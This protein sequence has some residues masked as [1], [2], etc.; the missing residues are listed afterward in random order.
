MNFLFIPSWFPEPIAKAIGWTLIHSLWQGLLVTFIAGLMILFTKRSAASIRYKLLSFLLFAFVA[1]ALATFVIEYVSASKASEVVTIVNNT[2]VDLTPVVVNEPVATGSEAGQS[3]FSSGYFSAFTN[4]FNTNAPLIVTIWF[5]IF[6][7]KCFRLT[8]NIASAQRIRKH[9][10]S[11]LPVLQRRLEELAILMKIKALV[12]VHESSIV[13]VPSVIGFLKPVILLPVGLLSNLPPDQVEAIL[14]HELAHIRRKDY[15]VNLLQCVVVT[16]FFFNPSILWLSSLIR[17]ERE[18][19][20]D[21]MAI[22]IL[23]TK[24][25]Y[26]N[27]LVAFTEY[28]SHS[29][30]AQ[31]FPGEKYP[32]LQRIKRIVYNHNKNLNNMEKIF[33]SS[34]VVL[35]AALILTFSATSAQEPVKIEQEKTPT[36][37][38]IGEKRVSEHRQVDG[39]VNDKEF[40]GS[41]TTSRDGKSYTIIVKNNV[42]KGLFVDS[43]RIPDEK[44]GDYKSMTDQIIADHINASNER[45]R[46]KE[47]EKESKAKEK[48]KALKDKQ[49]EYENKKKD[50]E[51]KV[52]EEKENKREKQEEAKEEMEEKRR[53]AKED[54]EEKQREEKEEKEEKEFDLKSEKEFNLKND[55]DFKVKS[56]K[57][58]EYKDKDGDKFKKNKL[59]KVKS[60][61]DFEYQKDNKDAQ[62]KKIAQQKEKE[63]EKSQKKEAD[64][65]KEK[66]KAQQKEQ[67]SQQKQIEREKKQ[68]EKENERRKKEL[69]IQKEAQQGVK[70]DIREKKER[71]KRKEEKE[72]REKEDKKKDKD[73]DN[74]NDDN[75]N[76][77]DNN[78][79]GKRVSVN[80]KFPGIAKTE[81]DKSIKGA[82][83][84]EKAHNVF[85][86]ERNSIVLVSGD[87]KLNIGEP[88]EGDKA[89]TS[90]KRVTALRFKEGRKPV[91]AFDVNTDKKSAPSSSSSPS[92][93][94]PSP[95]S[96]E[97]LIINDLKSNNLLKAETNIVLELNFRE[98]RL[99]GKKMT[100]DIH[101]KF[102]TKYL[103]GYSD[104][105]FFMHESENK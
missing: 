68:Q 5:A 1:G 55:K 91:V 82:R 12:I 100:N 2:G 39:T 33:L 30:Y 4:Y 59:F 21:D 57:E 17:Q 71:E 53:E 20:C 66:Q 65:K 88:A 40:T 14:L 56:E 22:D 19:C 37:Q 84:S 52:K 54:K 26:I 101:K 29:T 44:F 34:G 48:E 16:I 36:Q 74:D 23:G 60:D 27:A 70:D 43:E 28:R 96:K 32:V 8:A 76:D 73:D 75:D 47:I 67:E 7:F 95:A 9:K 45:K 99:N 81:I 58:F 105:I 72:K 93:R 83:K 61:K 24:A 98:M 103:K 13:K 85:I 69:V 41:I 18:N 49:F 86:E 94:A 89:V 63:K 51:N 15:L 64:L 31:A 104:R 80:V 62:E 78:N 102:K 25:T 10:V 38:V 77:D 6:L 3:F 97:E 35:C 11:P 90:V 92:P 42:V 46:L 50:K 87:A 79:R